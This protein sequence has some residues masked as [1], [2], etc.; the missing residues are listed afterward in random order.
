MTWPQDAYVGQKVVCIKVLPLIHPIHMMMPINL[1]EVYEISA[2]YIGRGKLWFG[3]T[4]WPPR[5]WWHTEQFRPVQSTSISYS[6]LAK[7]QDPT[8]HR[9][10]EDVSTNS[11]VPEKVT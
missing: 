8:T 2:L 9:D 5:V 3:L 6:I 4:D 10:L 1:N 11:P 7:L